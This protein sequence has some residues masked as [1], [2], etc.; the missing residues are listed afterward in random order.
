[1]LSC[2]ISTAVAVKRLTQECLSCDQCTTS[3]PMQMQLMRILDS[4]CL[5]LTSS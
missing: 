5:G 4:T 2:L 3:G 1:M